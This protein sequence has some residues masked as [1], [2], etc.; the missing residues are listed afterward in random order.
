V[1]GLSAADT[2]WAEPLPVV[3]DNLHRLIAVPGRRCTWQILMQAQAVQLVTAAERRLWID[4]SAAAPARISRKSKRV[5]L[6]LLTAMNDRQCSN[7]EWRPPEAGASPRWPDAAGFVAAV[8]KKASAV[9][10]A[11][12]QLPAQRLM[13]TRPA[14]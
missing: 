7:M 5:P 2:V 11:G 14:G 13:S 3:D 8:T 6:K 10:V 12:G 1:V 4:I 9:T